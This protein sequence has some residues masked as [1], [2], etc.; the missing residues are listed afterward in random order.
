MWLFRI[1]SEFQIFLSS[2]IVL[3]IIRIKSKSKKVF[4]GKCITRIYNKAKSTYTNIT[5]DLN[6]IQN[7]PVAAQ[8]IK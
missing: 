7:K 6:T 4:I 5:P 2:Y 1:F 8:P 3:E